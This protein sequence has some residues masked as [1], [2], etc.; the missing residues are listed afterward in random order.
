MQL[1]SHTRLYYGRDDGQPTVP[2]YF[3]PK[4]SSA[5]FNI[6]HPRVVPFILQVDISP[7]Q[8]VGMVVYYQAW[9]DPTT[10]QMTYYEDTYDTIWNGEDPQYLCYDLTPAQAEYLDAMLTARLPRNRSIFAEARGG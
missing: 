6:A 2:G 4:H 3:P 5:P 1:A 10:L 7:P 8:S 9:Y